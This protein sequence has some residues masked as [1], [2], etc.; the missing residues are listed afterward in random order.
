MNAS[1]LENNFLAMEEDF[2]AILASSKKSLK[3]DKED[4][5]KSALRSLSRQV[6]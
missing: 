5:E 2:D 1:Q 6:D 3:K 4:L